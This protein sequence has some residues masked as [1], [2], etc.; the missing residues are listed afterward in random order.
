V[1]LD[2]L[3]QGPV[4]KA[5]LLWSNRNMKNQTTMPQTVLT[6]KQEKYVFTRGVFIENY[7]SVKGFVDDRPV[8]PEHLCLKLVQN[9]IDDGVPKDAHIGVLD[10]T[11]VLMLYLH[12]AG[13]TNLTLL[14]TKSV[15]TLRKKDQDWLSTI[16]RLCEL[17]G[18]RVVDHMSKLHQFDVVIGNPP[19]GVGASLAIK[20]LNHAFE[21][22]N[23]VRLVM[24][25]SLTQRVSTLNRVRLD[26]VCKSDEALPNDTFHSN[27]RA[28][29]QQWV[30]GKRE[31]VEVVT[32]HKD[33]TWLKRESREIPDLVI[34]GTGTRS[35]AVYLPDHPKF[36]HYA[37]ASYYLKIKASPEVVT[38]FVDLEQDL[39]KAADSCNGRPHACK[40]L[41]VT[42]YN[43][44]FN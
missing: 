23:D 25:R 37:N 22:C 28:N 31:K 42:V 21:I 43:Q 2:K 13:F 34:R 6:Q 40:S 18:V 35:G 39:I 24:P 3:A 33:W 5:G 14:N 29:Y 4:S 36:E 41:V 1:T 26:I 32:S 11:P 7:A 9:L 20:F 10:S 30:S 12:E 27:I 44:R 17:N 38:R 16:K 15:K 8:M 19:Y